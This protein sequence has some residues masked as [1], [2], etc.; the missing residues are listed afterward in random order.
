MLRSLFGRGKKKSSEPADDTLMS[1]R[2]GDVVVIGGFSP[3]FE[4][5][6][7]LIE[8]RSRYEA[9]TG[10][11]HEFIGVDGDRRVGIEFSEGDD[12]PFIS[13]T[14]QD[15][16]MGLSS[17]GL[18]SDQLIRMDEEH[19]IDNF[20]T[21]EGERYYYANSREI[22]FFNDSRGEGEGFYGWDFISEDRQKMLSAV[23]WEGAPFELYHSVVVSPLIVS[24]YRNLP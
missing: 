12:G 8:K 13:V 16:P 17:A 19:S 18:S 20:I 21:Y 7:F 11:W 2:V 10:G 22:Y 1:A 5:A 3:T 9:E 23:K 24:V 4:D 14:E 6:Y 15:A